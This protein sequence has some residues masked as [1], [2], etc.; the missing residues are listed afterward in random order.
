MS[1]YRWEILPLLHG[2]GRLV[3]TDGR[4]IERLY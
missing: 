1:E 3:Y 2:G 4:F